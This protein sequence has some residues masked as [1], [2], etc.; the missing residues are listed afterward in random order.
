MSEVVK[1]KV[2][3]IVPGDNDR[4][5]FDQAGLIELAESIR[6]LGLVQPITV[7]PLGGGIFQICA[8]ERRFRAISQIL[9]DEYAPCIV[10]ELT[11]DE[12]S[13]IMLSENIG[14]RDLDPVD[15][16]FAYQKR[17]EQFG[18]TPKDIEQKCGVSAERVK[19]RL[20]LVNVRQDILALVKSGQ[21]PV[22]HAEALAILDTNRQMIAARPLIEG[23]SIAFRAFRALVDQLHAE[24][25]SESL[26]DLALFGGDYP[27]PE[28]VQIGKVSIP[29]APD[30]PPVTIPEVHTTGAII[31][32]YIQTLT[33][34]GMKREAEV[35][36]TI[37][38]GLCKSNYARIPV[39]VSKT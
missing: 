7:R 4:T 34:S 39:T 35:I 18:W 27:E 20:R 22:G 19:K 14:R 5:T 13:A 26:F 30:L 12:A 33:E 3:N 24:Q 6:Q 28:Q 2:E 37:L 9:K 8:G 31:Y 25:C 10:R 29:T 15:E 16:A 11:D 17:V 32:N 23:Q 38:A 1:I 36:G 21:F